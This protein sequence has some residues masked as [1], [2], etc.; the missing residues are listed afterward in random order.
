MGGKRG[1]G[2]CGDVATGVDMGEAAAGGD[3]ATEGFFIAGGVDDVGAS[4]GARRR[5]GRGLARGA[6]A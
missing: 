1:D 6:T 5:Q 3:A 2:T 4:D